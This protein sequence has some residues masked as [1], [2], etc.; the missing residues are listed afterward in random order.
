MASMKSIRIKINK[1]SA[2]IQR[3]TNV[4]RT[5]PV[6]IADDIPGLL[7][8]YPG[9]YSYLPSFSNALPYQF[10]STTGNINNRDFI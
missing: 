10:P 2:K 5:V 9:N 4:T 8:I 6:E 1:I 3:Q 7:T